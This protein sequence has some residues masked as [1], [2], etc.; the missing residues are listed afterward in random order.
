MVSHEGF[1]ILGYVYAIL[2]TLGSFFQAIQG[3]LMIGAE[4]VNETVQY[5]SL[6]GSLIALVFFVILLVGIWQSHL[7]LVKIYRVFLIV[8]NVAA[9]CCICI[10]LVVLIGLMIFT[11]EQME[12]GGLAVF[13]LLVLLAVLIGL[14][15]LFLW[16]MNGVI[17]AIQNERTGNNG[18]VLYKPDANIKSNNPYYAPV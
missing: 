17:A 12:L 4:H 13:G 10:G 11:D 9:I 2:G 18:A 14:Y 7:T 3:A 15:L 6:P 5:A 16:I 1:R 8:T